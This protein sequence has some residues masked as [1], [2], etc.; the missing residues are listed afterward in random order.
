M[1]N[2]LLTWLLGSGLDEQR[3]EIYLAALQ[4]GEA[5][6]AEL[7][8]AL[9]IGRTAMYDNLR[10]LEA[11]GYVRTIL[12]GKRK[13]FVPL[14]PKELLKRV[15]TQKE[16]LKDLLPDF[17]AL[18]AEKSTIPFVR[19]FH[20]P[21]AAREV[22][23]DILAT[24]KKEYV[25]FS[26]PSATLQRTD[27][28]YMKKWIERRVK[29]GVTAQALRVKE[30]A[31]PYDALFDDEA[32]FLRQV[33]YLPAYVN[34]DATIYIYEKNIAS[35]STKKE[36]AAFIIHSGDLAFSLRQLFDFLWGISVRT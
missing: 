1:K 3:A 14:H 27:R 34:L 28:V 4:K 8:D 7:A 26:A 12:A 18:Y 35:I 29:K 5:T 33:R 19:V 9:H 6:A 16:Q 2:N 31:L 20:G 17:L 13:M 15:E 25:Y 36:G 22:F 11:R 32:A 24:T 23:E 10:V 30:K 21:F